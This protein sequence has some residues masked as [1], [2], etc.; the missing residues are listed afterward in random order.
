MILWVLLEP[1]AAFNKINHS[2]LLSFL[3]NLG[4]STVPC[5]YS[6]STVCEIA[7]LDQLSAC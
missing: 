3:Q 6:T 7:G 1:L 5:S 4:L 2:T